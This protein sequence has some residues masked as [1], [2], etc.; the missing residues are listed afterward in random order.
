MQDNSKLRLL[1]NR[2]REKAPLVRHLSAGS[3]IK[4]QNIE[5]DQYE[6][7]EVEEKLDVIDIDSKMVSKEVVDEIEEEII[8][9]D[10][11]IMEQPQLCLPIRNNVQWMCRT[12]NNE[13]L[14]I[15]RESR[16]I[17]GHRRKDHANDPIGSRNQLPCNTKS[18]ICSH[19]FY[20]VG[21]GSWILR[22]NCKHK[23][24]DHNPDKAP[25]S[26]K[27][28]KGCSA[29]D[30]PW[31]CNC[32]HRWNEHLQ[33]VLSPG[34]RSSSSMTTRVNHAVRKDGLI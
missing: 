34:D 28:C 5:A 21:E 4:A 19:F 17:C 22:C 10:H 7:E 16:C 15:T 27:K 13:C 30:S 12:C 32:G 25:Y 20:I 3:L 29:F 18:C 33:R 8:T 24:I 1:K 9:N 2:I 26:C 11:N 31:V 14:A 23:H 6:A